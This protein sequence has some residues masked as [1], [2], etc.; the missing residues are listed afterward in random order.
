MPVLCQ[1]QTAAMFP[2]TRPSPTNAYNM[3]HFGSYMGGAQ[4]HTQTPDYSQ[5][6]VDHTGY[7]NCYNMYNTAATRPQTMDDWTSY[8]THGMTAQM[9]ASTTPPSHYS[10]KPTHG[11]GLA[12]YA[13]HT[14]SNLTVLESPPQPHG[15]SPV[16]STSSGSSLSPTNKQLRPAYEWM[17]PN[18]LTTTGPSQGNILIRT[19]Y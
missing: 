6:N 18:T 1:E 8:S 12:D 14:H 4:Y 11:I 13:Q 19:K 5:F 7:Q 3:G 10:Y 15:A 2:S 9:P 17:K 16:S